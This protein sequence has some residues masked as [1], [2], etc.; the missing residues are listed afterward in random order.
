MPRQV[1]EASGQDPLL[2]SIRE[3]LKT[4]N[5]EQL[6]GTTYKAVRDELWVLGYLVMRGNRI[7]MPESLRDRTIQ[8]AHEGHQGMVRTKARLREKVWWPQMDEQVEN[9]V[10]ACHPCQL[11]G[12]RSKPEPI[13]STTLPEGPWTDVAIDLCEILGGD[14][15]LVIIDY[16]SRWPEV[17][18]L[19]KTDASRKAWKPCLER[20]AYQTQCAATTGLCFQGI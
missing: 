18:L 13:R 8:V 4:G 12:P 14:H 11:V 19:E 20:T 9:A 2:T 3:A 17:V 6:R 15:L 16:Y 5:W 1:E 7:V 10:R